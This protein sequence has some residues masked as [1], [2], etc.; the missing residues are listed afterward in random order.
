MTIRSYWVLN[1]T[2]IIA[3]FLLLFYNLKPYPKEYRGRVILFALALFVPFTLASRYGYVAEG[4]FN[5]E[6]SLSFTI[7]G[8]VSL[9]WGLIAAALCAFPVAKL[10][11]TDAWQAADLFSFSLAAGG[12]FA[13]LGCF[14]NGCCTGIPAPKGYFFGT[15]YSPYSYAYN[16][17][18][19]VPLHPAQ[20]YESCA[21]LIILVILYL[22]KRHLVYRGEL[23]LLAGAC[24]AVARFIIEFFRYHEVYHFIYAARV[25]CIIVFLFTSLM[26]IFK[27]TVLK[28]Y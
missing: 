17:F 15:F 4:F 25:F 3:G 9:W 1:F 19:N 11:K 10:L 13:R 7:F 6:K 8:P 23:I 14:F 12:I 20:L 16:V 5:H 22:K 21:W 24:Y 2:G 18:G 26:W 28:K 27:K